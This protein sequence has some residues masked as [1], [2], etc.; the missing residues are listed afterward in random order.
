MIT[1]NDKN[2]ISAHVTHKACDGE[3]KEQNTLFGSYIYLINN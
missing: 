3:K 2:F 1:V